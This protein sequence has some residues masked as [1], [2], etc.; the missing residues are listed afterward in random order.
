[1]SNFYTNKKD[2][3]AWLKDNIV[4]PY[5]IHRDLSVSVHGDVQLE[6]KCDYLPVRFNVVYGDFYIVESPIRSLEGCPKVVKCELCLYGLPNIV[7]LKGLPK[8]EDIFINDCEGLKSLEG[9]PNRVRTYKVTDCSIK[10]LKHSPRYISHV[11]D[12]SLNPITSFIGGPEYV[13]YS[14]YANRCSLRSTKGFPKGVKETICLR[15]N[16]LKKLVDMPNKTNDL[17][18]DDNKIKTFEGF[19]KLIGRS[20]H[21]DNNKIASL[22]GMPNITKNTHTHII[23]SKNPIT[24]LYGLKP[25]M[26]ISLSSTQIENLKNLPSSVRILNIADCGSLV[27][28]DHLVDSK[29]EF[30]FINEQLVDKLGF[31]KSSV[32]WD[33]ACRY[34]K[35]DLLSIIREIKLKQLAE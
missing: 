23:L 28:I 26:S 31:T 34:T 20:I 1:M 27:N 32:I 3:I 2:I 6:L 33:G 7:D 10:S 9:S 21:M 24:S 19:P 22:V 25:S 12:V 8:C 4:H 14:V 13:G 18:L 11:F 29:V 5:T 17:Y 16:N 35:S 15:N 30:L